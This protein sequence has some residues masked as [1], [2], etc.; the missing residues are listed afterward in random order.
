MLKR[1][2]DIVFSSIGLFLLSPLFLVTAVILYLTSG[3][4]IFFR[5]KR[6]GKYCNIFHIIKFRTMIINAEEYGTY[7]TEFNDKRITRFGKILRKTSVDEL[8]QLFNV[9]VGEMSLV[10]PR[11][12]VPA[13]RHLYSKEEWLL[14]HTVRP[15]ITGLAQSTH[16]SLATTEQRKALDIEYVKEVNLLLDLKILIA[17]AFQLGKKGVN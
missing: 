16:R 4:P 6:V 11:P 9:L 3:T 17:T 12:D 10:G 13:Q 7:K 2:F 8:P 14:R 1:M 15:G 5:Q